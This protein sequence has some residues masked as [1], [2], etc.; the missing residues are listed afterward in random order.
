MGRQVVK[1]RQS[2]KSSRKRR[3]QCRVRPRGAT[4]RARSTRRGGRGSHGTTLVIF[5]LRFP[6]LDFSTCDARSQYHLRSPVGRA[7]PSKARTSAPTAHRAAPPVERSPCLNKAPPTVPGLALQSFY[8]S[9]KHRQL[10]GRIFKAHLLA[11]ALRAATRPRAG[12]RESNVTNSRSELSKYSTVYKYGHLLGNC[13]AS[14]PIQVVRRQ[15]WVVDLTT[16]RRCVD[17]GVVAR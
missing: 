4:A 10:H 8:S 5:C 12:R 9:N 17:A 1:R 6:P 16:K 13:I 7:A 11:H 15:S 2:S 3:S 14:S